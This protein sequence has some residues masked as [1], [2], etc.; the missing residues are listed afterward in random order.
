[1]T[2]CAN[3]SGWNATGIN[4][5]PLPL[6][7]GT[8]RRSHEKLKTEDRQATPLLQ[9]LKYLNIP[10]C[11]LRL[12]RVSVVNGCWTFAPCRDTAYTE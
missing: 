4:P 1:M 9:K 5:R 10:L 7:A 11:H 12:L 3:A 6:E 2:N 8:A